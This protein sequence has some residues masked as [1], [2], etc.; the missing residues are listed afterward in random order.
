MSDQP[1]IPQAAG[2]TGILT[3]AGLPDDQVHAWFARPR[4][5]LAGLTPGVAATLPGGGDTVLDL[6]R[7]DAL[8]ISA[9]LAGTRR[10]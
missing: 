9:D 8:A 2:I 6:A 7:A 4:R 1:Q 5:E 3:E 10:G